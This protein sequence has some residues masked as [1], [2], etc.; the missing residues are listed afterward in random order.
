MEEH[1]ELGIVRRFDFVPKLQRMSVITKNVN[2]NFY[3][4]FCKGSPEKLKELCLPETIPETFNDTLNKYAIKGFRILA[5]AFKTIKMSYIQSQ[6]ITR[7]KAES[8]MIFLGLLIVQNKLKPETRPTLNLLENA[9]LKMV[10][11]TGDNI[12]TAISVSKECELIKKNSLV[13]SCEIEGKKLVWN[14]IENFDEENDPGEFIIEPKKEGD[15]SDIVFLEQGKPMKETKGLFE[16]G[17]DDEINTSSNII[18]EFESNINDVNDNK[19]RI[20]EYNAMKTPDNIFGDNLKINDTYR[21]SV[22]NQ[23]NQKRVSIASGLDY[24]GSS[25]IDNFPPDRYSILYS[26][27]PSV[28]VNVPILPHGDKEINPNIPT[29]E[30]SALMGLE[31]KEYPFQNV[32]EDYVIAMTG[33][34]FEQLSMLR[35]QFLETENENLRIYN[36]I[37]RI[38]LL[39]GRVFARMAPEHKALL[40]DGFKKKN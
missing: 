7:D 29:D 9:G 33:K 18:N 17:K 11:A 2:E 28:M 34:T 36:D 37:F 25:F 19:L 16:K 15:E 3:K 12:L 20:S 23:G 14:A 26:K 30:D 4:V 8:K 10:M 24:D 13:Y 40:V 27:R 38:I 32:Q 35:Q 39:H 6:Q 22:F 21:K 31:I 1:Y 5:M